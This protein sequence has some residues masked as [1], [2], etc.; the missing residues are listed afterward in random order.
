[1]SGE[2]DIADTD[3][4][5]LDDAASD[6]G[7]EGFAAAYG[8]AGWSP[9]EAG[10]DE[11][12]GSIWAA[13][14]IRNEW[15]PLTR[16]VLRAPGPALAD[17]A[18]APNASQLLAPLDLG[19]AQAEHAQLVA[20]YR[21]A[22]VEV[23]ELPPSETHANAMFCAD[24]FAMTREGA[25][26]ARPASTVRAGEEVAMA[27][28]LAAERVPI[29]ATL[30]GDAVFEGADLMWVDEETVLFGRGLRSNDAALDQ[31]ERVLDGMDAGA[32][33]VDLPVGT[34]HLMGMLRIL[35]AD[36]AVAWP[37][38]TPHA[39]VQLLRDCDYRVVFPPMD[40]APAELGTGLNA[41]TLGPRKVLMPGGCPGMRAF[42]EAQAVEVIE[43]PMDELRKA[44][45]AMGC[46][47]GILARG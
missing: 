29:L 10:H 25:I 33:A 45:G 46:L 14:G 15:A 27:A 4:T 40:L 39:A 32:T 5:E 24:L 34:M 47:T 19:R 35:A 3:E 9:R 44:A 28:A 22:G 43:T 8:G 31:I 7:A 16:V 6:A 26:L 20:A 42:Y 17:A 23:L 36:L 37:G 1:M 18:E 41:V 13:C 2:D 30:T 11:E 38:R 12:L 21:A